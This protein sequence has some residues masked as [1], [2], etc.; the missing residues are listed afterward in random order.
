MTDHI[1]FDQPVVECVPDPFIETGC[2]LI[3]MRLHPVHN[4]LAQVVQSSPETKSR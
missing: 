2:L 1:G 4:D 3:K